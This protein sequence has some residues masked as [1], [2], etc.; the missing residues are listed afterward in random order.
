MANVLPAPQPGVLPGFT[1]VVGPRRPRATVLVLHGGAEHNPLPATARSLSW[2][3]ARRLLRD[4]H[5]PLERDGI[6]MALLR[7]RMIGWNAG[8]DDEPSPVPDAR[9]ALDRLAEQHGSPVAILGHS[10]GA[11]TAAA[12]AGHETVR[13]VVGL[14]PWLP[15]DDPVEGLRGKTLLTAH[16]TRDKITSPRATR[17]YVARAA[18]VGTARH[19]DLDG[20]GHYMLREVR[21]WNRFALQACRE[22]LND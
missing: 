11:R 18:E 13:G 17:R 16:G 6:A 20:V 2:R 8:R 14:A 10:M 22:I 5:K 3:R 19:T 21:T 1:D 12:V 15:P 4:L 7:Y 9:W